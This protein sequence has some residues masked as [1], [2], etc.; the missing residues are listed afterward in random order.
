MNNDKLPKIAG[1]RPQPK[2]GSRKGSPNKFTAEV[3]EMILLALERAGGVEYLAA[4]AESHPGPFMAL[5]GKVM[6]MQ[7]TGA[8]GGPLEIV[9]IRRVVVDPGAPKT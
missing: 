4:K 6:P 8:D 1:K 3:K 5:L 7:V 9:E 2:G